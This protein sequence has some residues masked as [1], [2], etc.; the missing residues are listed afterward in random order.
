MTPSDFVSLLREKKLLLP[1]IS[2]YTDFPYRT[3]LAQFHPPFLIT[4]M[5]HARAIVEGNQKTREI[6]RKAE[7]KHYHGVQLFGN[8]PLT[9]AQAAVL[10]EKQGRVREFGST[11]LSRSARYETTCYSQAPVPPLPSARALGALSQSRSQ[12]WALWRLDMVYAE[13]QAVPPALRPPQGP[14]HTGATALPDPFSNRLPALQ[15]LADGGRAGPIAAAVA[16]VVEEV[17]RHRHA[18]RPTA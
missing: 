4:E 6:L 3:I 18:H 5:A 10:V 12:E 17:V 15:P 9:L 14:G 13:R 1:P 2:G 11:H 16:D 8:D 7:G